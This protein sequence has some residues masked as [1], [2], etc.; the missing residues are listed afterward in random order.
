MKARKKP[1]VSFTR[2]DWQKLR[3]AFEDDDSLESAVLLVML[4]TGVR[5]GDVLRVERSKLKVALFS[6]EGIIEVVQKGGRKRLI[7][8]FGAEVYW[9]RLREACNKSARQN[10]DA[11]NDVA[12]VAEAVCPASSWGARGGGGAYQRV[13]RHLHAIATRLRVT[14][15][16]HLHRLRRTVATTALAKTKDIHLVRD[17]L[18]HASIRSTEHYVDEIRSAEVAVLQKQLLEG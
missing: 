10:A 12:T 2:S 3:G 16:P 6:S 1:A 14:G 18:G 5:I 11:P 13:N 4:S 9:L 7:P 8:V 15:R 17:L